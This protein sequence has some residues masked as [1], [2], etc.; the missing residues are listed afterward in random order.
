MG[1]SRTSMLIAAAVLVTAAG[2]LAAFLFVPSLSG[3]KSSRIRC[4]LQL[5]RP[6]P[7]PAGTPLRLT[8]VTSGTRGAYDYD[9]SVDNTPAGHGTTSENRFSVPVE[10]TVA[11]TSYITVTLTVDGK[12]RSFLFSLSIS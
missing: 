2:I 11:G 10:F 9:V 5:D 8:F 3:W 1:R 6:A 4:S 7:L 12:P